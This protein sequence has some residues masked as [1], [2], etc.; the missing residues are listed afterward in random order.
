MYNKLLIPVTVVLLFLLPAVQ[1]FAGGV[2]NPSI[3][4]DTPS[5][6]SRHISLDWRGISEAA[7]KKYQWA[8]YRFDLE[9]KT[10]TLLSELEPFQTSY[11]DEDLIPPLTRYYYKVENYQKGSL[12]QMKRERVN[13]KDVQNQ[14]KSALQVTPGSSL[15]IAQPNIS[16]TAVESPS[17]SAAIGS[18]NQIS[19]AGTLDLEYLDDD[20]D[21]D[22]FDDIEVEIVKPEAPPRRQSY[23]NEGIYI[24]VI[25]F[26]GKVSDI[27]QNRDGNPALV[28]LDGSGR[29]ALIEHLARGYVPSKSSGTALYYADHKALANLSAMRSDG[30]LP[31]NIDS[32]TII[33]FTDGIDTSSTDASFK[34]LDERPRF[35]NSVSYRDF[36]S[37][38]LSAS[39]ISRRLP[40]VKKFNAWSIGIPGKDVQNNIEFGRGLQAV[41]PDDY[42]EFTN[43]SQIEKIL[44]GI[45]DKLLLT[46]KPRVNLT[47]SAPAYP[48]GTQL[49]I[50]FDGYTAD[51]SD[52]Y[53][54]AYVSWDEANK[55]Y[56]LAITEQTG[57]KLADNKRRIEGR[58]DEIGID[59]TMMLT[60]EFLESNVQQ[61]YIQPGEEAS[62]WMQNS[63]VVTSKTADFTYERKSEIIYLVLDSSS[64]LNEKD[65]TSIRSAIGVFINRLYDALYDPAV[66]NSI[67][68]SSG[69]GFSN[70]KSGQTYISAEKTPQAVSEVY[71]QTYK[72]DSAGKSSQPVSELVIQTYKPEATGRS[73]QPASGYTSQTYSQSSGTTIPARQSSQASSGYSSQPQQQGRTAA[74]PAPQSST[75]STQTYNQQSGAGIPQQS[76]PYTQQPQ[77]QG[78]AAA[79]SAPQSST[80]STQTYNQQGGAGIPQQSLPY[81]QQS[82]QQGWAVTPSVPQS[83]TYSTQ[84]YN[85]Q[86]GTPQ[87]SLTYTPQTQQQGRIV[88]PSAQSF[89]YN[90][91]APQTQ[92]GRVPT[93]A[94][95]VSELTIQTYNQSGVTGSRPVS[96]LTIQTYKAGD[97]ASSRT[98]QV[99]IPSSPVNKSS[100][101][102]ART[103]QV[104]IPSL[105]INRP[106]NAPVSEPPVQTWQRP[107]QFPPSETYQ[108]PATQ[109]RPAEVNRSASASVPTNITVRPVIELFSAANAP[110]N[111]P[112]GGNVYW[113]QL[114]S[115]SNANHAQRS[116]RSFS[117]TGIGSAEIFSTNV[118]GTTYYRVKAGP[119]P[120]KTDAERA[121]A[122]LKNYSQDYNDSFITNE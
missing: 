109:A 96:E 64:S 8:I 101:A 86:S 36:I 51:A 58:R 81:T 84:T 83:S 25:S 88:T 9:E 38:Q 28:L 77:Q 20:D 85:Q 122:Q 16:Y 26:S 31:G 18:P 70:G 110:A 46:Y 61:W 34:P 66:R 55:S 74:P 21:T 68:A 23:L 44:L 120:T 11:L 32:V 75:Y 35:K 112:S 19:G 114:G 45:A 105:Q 43:V 42:S 2:K 29:Q 1:A 40:G 6:T 104:T 107:G 92:Q 10:F 121:L 59:Y 93:P 30:S 106:P 50:T 117:N 103:P 95:P 67:A 108:S 89:T 62:G 115:Y 113:I 78:W 37:K 15:N 13:Q 97:A 80:Y 72:P 39:A 111:R 60:D 90:N 94:Q 65:I 100:E 73:D 22:F 3:E 33:T 5:E 99:T 48:V 76:L 41:G 24:G 4:V 98:P 79:P 14:L 87:Q 102:T 69:K 56:I 53:I 12:K 57:M 116:W 82:Q 54:D 27:T 7:V 119:Y 17:Q 49:R 52:R 91:T 118:N 63:E 71:I 47:L